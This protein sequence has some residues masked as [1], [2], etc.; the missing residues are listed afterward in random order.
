MRTNLKIKALSALSTAVPLLL[1]ATES[2]F[3]QVATTTVPSTG[4]GA[5]AVANLALLLGS[6]VVLAIGVMYLRKLARERS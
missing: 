4:A 6:V 2:A 5:S 1:L 3:A